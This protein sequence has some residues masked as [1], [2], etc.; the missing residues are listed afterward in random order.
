LQEFEAFESE[1]AAKSNIVAAVKSVSQRLGNTPA[2]CRKAYI[3]PAVIE[4]YMDGSMLE[5]LKQKTEE[6]LEE[7]LANLRPEEA[8][9][10]GLL[11]QKLSRSV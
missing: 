11:Q 3:H 8:A 1:T 2:V 7:E 9:V 10:L 5:S 4:S 6:T